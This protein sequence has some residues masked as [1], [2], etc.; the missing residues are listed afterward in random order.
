MSEAR[1]TELRLYCLCGQKMKIT[2]NMLGKPGK[3]VA[4]RQKIRI[5]SREELP[6][7]THTLYLKDHPEYLRASQRDVIALPE[8]VSETNSEAEG[9]DVVLSG[10]ADDLAPVPFVLYEPLGR[11][12]NYEAKVN[13]QLADLRGGKASELDQTTLMSYRGLARKARQTLE[14][15]MRDELIDVASELQSLREGLARETAALR[16]AE[17]DYPEFSK[18]VLPLRKRREVLACRHQNLRGWLS[19]ED[20]HMAGGHADVALADVPVDS[21][22][23]PFP[24]ARELD[25]LPIEHSVL[26]LEEALRQ[27][28]KADRRLNELHRA[29]LDGKIP[30]E[31][32]KAQRADTD[33]ER[34]RARTGVA[35][36]RAR[37]QQVIQDC[38]E[39]SSAI[40]AHLDLKR[41]QLESGAITKAAYEVLEE[42]LFR[43]QLDIKRARNLATRA[44]N[45]NTISDVPN[46]R[47][48][49]LERLARP[50]TQQRGLGVDSWLGWLGSALLLS[51]IFV[52]L[53]DNVPGGNPAVFQG[54]TL[55]L[56]VG[57]AF[58]GLSVTLAARGPRAL[59]LGAMWLILTLAGAA[60]FQYELGAVGP[61]GSTLRAGEPWWASL[62]GQMLLCG[63]GV[64]AIAVLVSYAALPGLRWMGP[65][66]VAAGTA[67]ALGILN[68]YAGYLRALPVL[69]AVT[70]EPDAA[71]GAYA[72]TVPLRNRGNR[73]FWLGGDRV[74]VPRASDYVME[75]QG[76]DNAWIDAGAPPGVTVG[77]VN[78]GIN[79]DVGVP[80]AAGSQVAVH[81]QLVPGTYRV[82]FR[83][84]WGDGTVLEQT[85]QLEPFAV[86]LETFFP[87][88]GEGTGSA[89]TSGSGVMVELRGVVDGE[90]SQPKFSLIIT[91][92]DGTERREQFVLGD[93][94]HGEWSISEFN[95][96]HN[97]MTLSDGKR[98]LIV[99][100]GKPE[101][102]PK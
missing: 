79:L 74:S 60:Y 73:A 91:Q 93:K 11:L 70:M 95:P 59:A 41:R 72:V 23:A 100:R 83:P 26:K 10:E 46:P 28:E 12:C 27:R 87:P 25:S 21:I 68:D 53:G 24:L 3:C 67:L 50:G 75:L 86:D 81:H 80:V 6:E 71:S 54:L 98:L 44:L 30:A 34:E 84:E 9:D 39:D 35:F 97:T 69:E 4:C 65:V 48:T 82:Q 85:F 90:A 62:G 57:G 64:A 29:N 101:E 88:E 76:P 32:M 19:T 2:S 31:E 15:K 61:A 40:Q 43:A 22:D 18:R 36:Y 96:A 45:A 13:A 56:F 77:E 5:P 99:E 94:L 66:L 89:T 16:G 78:S 7:G 37:L 20:P 52:P 17:T 38:E 1:S 51:V 58:L 14:K 92:P 8:P 42:S 102:I 55:G 33:A 47:G 63:W 49:F